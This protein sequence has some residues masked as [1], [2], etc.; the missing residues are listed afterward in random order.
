[1]GVV[2][3]IGYSTSHFMQICDS[4]PA[5][6]RMSSMLDRNR[7]NYEDESAGWTATNNIRSEQL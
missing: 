3:P 4:S 5:I 1:M 7:A 6:V 2:I